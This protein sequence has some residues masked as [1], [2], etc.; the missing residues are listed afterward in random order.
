MNN[1]TKEELTL[2]LSLYY[3]DYKR[4]NPKFLQSFTDRFNKVFNKNVNSQIILYTCSLFQRLNPSHTAKPINDN[5]ERLDYLWNYYI[6]QDRIAELRNIYLNFKKNKLIIVEHMVL[7]DDNNANDVMQENFNNLTF[8]FEKDCPKELYTNNRIEKGSYLRD[9]NVSF[10]A[11]RIANFK[12]EYSNSHETFTRKNS[13]ITY[14]EGHHLIP[15]KFQNN[16]NVNLDVEANIVSLCSN[17]HNKLHYGQNYD[18]VLRVIFNKERIQRLKNCG[19]NISFEEL[20]SF[21]E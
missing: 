17:C 1:F 15:L 14:T 6:L 16:F 18:E 2:L 8:S 3:F 9:L 20:V 7:M 19:I 11:L 13:S 12:C 21:Y 4:L 10:N 5:D